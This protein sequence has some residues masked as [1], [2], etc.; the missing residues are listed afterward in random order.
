MSKA[1]DSRKKVGPVAACVLGIALVA[2][3]VVSACVGGKHLSAPAVANHPSARALT[4]P[5][6]LAA[7]L[8]VMTLNVAHGR[9]DGA[10]Q[11]LRKKATIRSNL[12]DIASA[13]SRVAPD[14]VALQEA[15]AASSWSGKFDHVVYLAEEAN[16]L[17]SVRGEHVS[18]LGVHCGT[19]L[20]SN[21]APTDSMSVTFSASAP[22]FPKGF[23]AAAIPWPG[24][25][26]KTT[27]VVSVHLDFTSEAVRKKQVEEMIDKLSARARPL[28]LMGDFNCQWSGKERTLRTLCERLQMSAYHPNSPDIKTF[29]TKKKRLDWI[30]ISRELEFV[31]Y[32]VLPDTLSD[33]QA[34]IAEIRPV[35]PSR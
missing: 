17:F 32:E 11:A 31:S 16:F 6:P 30:L 13:L 3:L 25:P 10:H 4:R 22:T 5:G 24:N 28:I 14:V 34:V 27:D 33:H 15:D 7:S 19:A 8:K 23:V 21:P 1:N 12:D 29:P 18:G 20:L 9:G 26:W 35:G 2:V